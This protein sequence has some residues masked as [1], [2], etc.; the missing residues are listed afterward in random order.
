MILKN[1]SFLFILLIVLGAIIYFR[2][3]YESKKNYEYFFDKK[4]VDIGKVKKTDKSEATYKL[5]NTGNEIIIIEQILTDCH[6]TTSKWKKNE[7]KKGESTSI[8]VGFDNHS[9][10]FFE[11]N[12]NVYIKGEKK[13][14]TLLI[15]RG[16]IIE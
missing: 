5:T 12:I 6:C 9:L 3:F 2:F 7:I 4:I 16:Y 8:V 15:F 1:N 13:P 11:Q 10:G 14:P